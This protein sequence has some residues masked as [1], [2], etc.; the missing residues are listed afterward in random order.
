MNIGKL[1]INV[2]A[3]VSQNMHFVYPAARQLIQFS[4]VRVYIETLNS[5]KFYTPKFYW[6]LH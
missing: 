6:L 2:R 4:Y 1:G 3:L 5:Y